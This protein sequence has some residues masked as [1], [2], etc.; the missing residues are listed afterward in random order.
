[1][2]VCLLLQKRCWCI[3]L[4]Y[5]VAVQT[6]SFHLS[7]LDL[8]QCQESNRKINHLSLRKINKNQAMAEQSPTRVSTTT[9]TTT[10]APQT[11]AGANAAYSTLRS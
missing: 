2:F 11:V 8:L 9:T 3:S 1:M 7:V 6:F 10:T 4:S 5:D